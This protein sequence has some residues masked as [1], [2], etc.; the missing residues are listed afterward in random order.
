[1]GEHQTVL[2]ANPQLCGAPFLGNGQLGSRLPAVLSGSHC[3]ATLHNK[4]CQM[5]LLV[6]WYFLVAAMSCWVVTSPFQRVL[7]SQHAANVFS[8]MLTT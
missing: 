1:M 7:Q 8:H 2:A 5:V 4:T 3:Q 6:R